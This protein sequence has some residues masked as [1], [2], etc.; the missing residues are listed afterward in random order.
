MSP[1]FLEHMPQPADLL[2]N[3]GTA[4]FDSKEVEEEFIWRAVDDKNLA[5]VVIEETSEQEG[6]HSY[7]P[8][9][10]DNRNINF[11]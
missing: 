4:V 2:Q 11:N 6:R 8:T 5:M 3:R 1:S 9:A 10:I 7:T